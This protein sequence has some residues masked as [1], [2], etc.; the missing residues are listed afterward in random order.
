MIA[1]LHPEL[2]VG[3]RHF[4]VQGAALSLSLIS[5]YRR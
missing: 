3:L 5:W 2:L 1:T 4:N